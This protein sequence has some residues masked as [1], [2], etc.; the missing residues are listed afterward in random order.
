[1]DPYNE[2]MMTDVLRVVAAVCLVADGYV[3]TLKDEVHVL[4]FSKIHKAEIIVHLHSTF[5]ACL[6]YTPQDTYN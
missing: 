1:M 3:H 4:F 5:E 2:S 6:H